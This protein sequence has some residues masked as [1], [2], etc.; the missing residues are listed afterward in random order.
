MTAKSDVVQID[1]GFLTD[2]GRKRQANQDSFAVLG[3]ADLGGRF[4]ALF[5][6]ADGMGGAR[7]GEVASRIVVQ[8]LP[9]TVDQILGRHRQTALDAEQVLYDAIVSAN[10]NVYMQK[11]ENPDLRGMGTTCIAAIIANGHLITGNV[12]DSRIYLLRKSLLQQLTED[13]SEVYE[14]VKAGEMTR[15]QARTSKFRNR[16]T[17]FIGA[18]ADAEPDIATWPLVE[19][20]TVLLCSDGLTTE[21]NDAQVARIL[22]TYPEAQQTCKHLVAAALE[23]GGSDN[24]TVV[25]V[26]YG[27]F[28]PLE[29][30]VAPEEA[31][32][33]PDTDPDAHWRKKRRQDGKRE[34]RPQGNSGWAVP[35]ICLLLTALVMSLVALA[36]VWNGTIKR[37]GE[38]AVVAAPKPPPTPQIAFDEDAKAT[39]VYKGQP[40]LDNVLQV[41]PDGNLLAV[42]TS[43][44]MVLITPDGQA[45]KAKSPQLFNGIA[46]PTSTRH[47]KLHEGA[48]TTAQTMVAVDVALDAQGNR[49]QIRPGTRCIEQV[50]PTGT[51]VNSTI[52]RKTLTAPTRIAI[53]P[54]TGDIYVI[55]NHQL[56][57][58]SARHTETGTQL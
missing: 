20:D 46:R 30:P 13:H 36:L 55:D 43:G 11:V 52:G 16:I 17:R 33:E 32:N 15:E 35:V 7:G 28:T 10:H 8:S 37:P 44:D 49:Y 40:L 25:V 56:K 34:E 18:N 54:Q 6:V 47:A 53:A 39:L 51:T 9:A 38:K 24:I 14:Q 2:V 58:I 26:R 23:R 48:G 45:Q 50:T 41:A 29:L 57:R 3:R 27:A 4:D 21:L 12:G 22:A 19:G 31:D 5:V 1:C 42:T